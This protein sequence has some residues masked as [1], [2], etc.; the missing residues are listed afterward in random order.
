MIDIRD[1]SSTDIAEINGYIINQVPQS[2]LPQLF[3]LTEEPMKKMK[4]FNSVYR[5]L[6]SARDFVESVENKDK[7][8]KMLDE[9]SDIY[10]KMYT[11][12]LSSITANYGLD[13][14]NRKIILEFKNVETNKKINKLIN[15]FL[16]FAE[17]QEL[18]ETEKVT[19]INL[20]TPEGL[21]LH[22]KLITGL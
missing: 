2:L 14:V 18:L 8:T 21:D 1:F 22:K 19:G 5:I 16:V 3:M 6:C 9:Y 13:G 17:K 7:M 10:N 12:Y 11:L 15:Y 20:D 4:V